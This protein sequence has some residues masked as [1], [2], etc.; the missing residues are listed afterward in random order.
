MPAKSQ[1]KTHFKYLYG[2]VNSWR[3][4]ISLGIDPLSQKSKVC[5]FDCLYCQLGKTTVLDDERKEFVKTEDLINEIKALPDMPIDYF[6]FSGKGEPTLAKNLGEM[7]TAIR[8]VRKEKIAVITNSSLMHRTDVQRELALA[9]FVLAKLDSCS[10]ETFET[11]HRTMQRIKFQ[12]IIDGIA[13]FKSSFKGKLAL[14]IMFIEG[15]RHYA[16][17]IAELARA[18]GPDEVE[19][20]TPLRPSPEWPLSREELEEIRAHFHGL[21]TI[22]VYDAEHKDIE[23][24]NRQDTLVRHGRWYNSAWEIFMSLKKIKGG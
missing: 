24:I 22:S 9:D 5:N 19:I 1:P 12:L 18:I 10:Q 11:V 17:Q 7:I 21:K 23:P 16:P 20:N 8:A 13:A 2:P 4:G 14:Q 15:N 3:L 6:T